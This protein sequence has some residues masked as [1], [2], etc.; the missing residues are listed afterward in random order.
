MLNGKSK[1]EEIEFVTKAEEGTE[2]PTVFVIKTL[3]HAER[4]KMIGIIQSSDGSELDN[5]SAMLKVAALG[6]IRI[7]NICIDGKSADI[8][9]SSVDDL[10]VVSIDAVIEV[11]AAVVDKNSI[12]GGDAKN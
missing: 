11:A 12:S 2:N 6:V 8:E 10:D 3:S 1:A 9:I 7:K 5:L 4:I